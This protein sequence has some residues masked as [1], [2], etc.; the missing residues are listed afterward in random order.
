MLDIIIPILRN[1]VISAAII[2][3][4]ISYCMSFYTFIFYLKRDKFDIMSIILLFAIPIFI[5]KILIN[6]FTL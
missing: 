3:S 5:I 4:I 2:V 1:V 6:E